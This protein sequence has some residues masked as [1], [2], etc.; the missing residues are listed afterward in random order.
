MPLLRGKS[1]IG[2]NIATE[3]AHGKKRK[4]AIAIA[5]AVSRKK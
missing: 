3:I 2:Q 4:Q 1:H 5:L